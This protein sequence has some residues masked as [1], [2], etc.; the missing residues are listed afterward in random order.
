MRF[1]LYISRFVY[2]FTFLIL[3]YGCSYETL[4]FFFDGVPEPNKQ[5]I[6]SVQ[7][8]IDSAKVIKPIVTPKQSSPRIYFHGPFKA[9]MCSN[10]HDLNSGYSLVA[11]EPQLCYGCHE[12]FTDDME[13]MHGPAA[14]GFCGQCHHPHQS[15]NKFVLRENVK[16]LC[17]KCHENDES[18]NNKLHSDAGEKICIE[19]H[20]PHG[21]NKQY[22]LM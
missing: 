1:R 15:E 21:G 3:V 12:N 7:T 22:F 2:I 17:N 13:F 14:A 4:T 8:E 5:K 11:P 9:K 6:E 19:C 20:S 16:T 10:C 18:F